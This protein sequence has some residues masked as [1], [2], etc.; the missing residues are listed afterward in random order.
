MSMLTPHFD[1]RL[2]YILKNENVIGISNFFQANG[3]RIWVSDSF[4]RYA[5][6]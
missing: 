2:L 5:T 6:K 3:I 4:R 1:I